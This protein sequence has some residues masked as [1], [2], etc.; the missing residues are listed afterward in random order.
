[1]IGHFSSRYKETDAIVNEA[2]AIFKNTDAVED[3]N[4]YQVLQ[5]RKEH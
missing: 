3:G 4:E 2:K 5:Q 1:L